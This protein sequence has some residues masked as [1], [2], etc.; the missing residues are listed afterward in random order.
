MIPDTCVPTSTSVTGSTVPVAVTELRIVMRLVAAVSSVIPVCFEGRS[1]NQSPQA[2]T[3]A[4]TRTAVL[5]RF[6]FMC[7]SFVF[8][9][10]FRSPEGLS[11]LIDVEQPD[12]EQRHVLGLQHL[13]PCRR[14]FVLRRNQFDGVLPA[15]AELLVGEVVALPGIAFLLPGGRVA[16]LRRDDVE[17]GRL[18]LAEQLLFE[19]ELFETAV[20]DGDARLV[21][22]RPVLA[23]REDRDASGCGGRPCG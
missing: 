14:K 4:A 20:R 11:S 3:R 19:T 7:F 21:D 10:R 8:S 15:D 2:A 17:V 6:I 5:F 9:G 23:V 22:G 13:L 16:R 1:A 12:V 18:D